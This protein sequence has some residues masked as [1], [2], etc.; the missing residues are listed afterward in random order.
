M[1]EKI[2]ISFDDEKPEKS[3]EKIIIDLKSTPKEKPEIKIQN[4]IVNSNFKGNPHL[5][6]F[7]SSTLKYP[8]GLENGFRKIFSDKLNDVFLNSIL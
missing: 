3:E 2:I 7:E 1:P 6:G 5:T 8:E 4:S